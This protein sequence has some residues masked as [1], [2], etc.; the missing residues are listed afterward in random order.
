ME[1]IEL[2]I[3]NLKGQIIKTFQLNPSTIQ[4]NNSIRWD[5]RNNNNQQVSSGLYFCQLKYGDF[6]ASK[7]MLLLK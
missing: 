4:H 5:G 6:Q 3:Y 7:K 2:I 1:N